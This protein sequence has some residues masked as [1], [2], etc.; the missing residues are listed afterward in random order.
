MF[1]AYGPQIIDS[2]SGE[3]IGWG[4]KLLAHLGDRFEELS[5]YGDPEYTRQTDQWLL[6]TRWL[7]PSEARA[8]Y[9]EVTNLEVG[10]RGGFKS[11]TFGSTRF[12]TKRLDP[13]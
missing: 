7:T 12:L 4:H 13:R 10:P 2:F 11:V 9:G 6:I 5:D 8:K 1:G 3:P